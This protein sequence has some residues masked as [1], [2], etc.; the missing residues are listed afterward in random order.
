[1]HVQVE[2]RGEIKLVK[3]LIQSLV[4]YMIKFKTIPNEERTTTKNPKE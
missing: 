1:M 3:N 2:N 4:L